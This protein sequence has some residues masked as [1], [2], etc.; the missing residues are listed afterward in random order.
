MRSN[1]VHVIA[2]T[3]HFKRDRGYPRGS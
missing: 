2:L 3:L 1:L